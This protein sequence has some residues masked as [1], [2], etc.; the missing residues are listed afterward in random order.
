MQNA[1][2]F[3][4]EK[5]LERGTEKY[6]S[7]ALYS[8]TFS[9]ISEM[10]A[11]SYLQFLIPL[12]RPIYT[13]VFEKEKM[14]KPFSEQIKIESVTDILYKNN[15]YKVKAGKEFFYS[16]NI[17]LA[18]E[19]SW[20]KNFAGVKKVNKPVDTNMLHVKGIPKNIIARKKYQLFS[21]PDNIQAVAD[22][23]DGTYLFY[24]K[25]K[26]PDLKNYFEKP[27]IIAHKFW[28]PAG[29]INGHNLIESN[30]GNSIS[31]AGDYNIAGLEES[32]VTG[33]YCANQIIKKE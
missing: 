4:K 8:T 6:L 2:D 13:F 18:T 12:V 17:V 5:K 26:K 9:N 15:L 19:I 33:L 10:N 11:F 32:F 24:Y 14:I 7:K 28:N 30:R 1:V 20:S 29:T 25:Y 3:I 16:K 22:L 31:L 27:E 23:E 21:P